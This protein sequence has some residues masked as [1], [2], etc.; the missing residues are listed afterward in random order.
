MSQVAQEVKQTQVTHETYLPDISLLILREKKKKKLKK[1]K[2]WHTPL[3]SGLGALS[4]WHIPEPEQMWVPCLDSGGA[5]A[6][7]EHDQTQEVMYV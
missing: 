5:Q 1:E 7:G 2:E 3:P 6:G 4:W